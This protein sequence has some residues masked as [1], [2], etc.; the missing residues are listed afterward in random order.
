MSI[1]RHQSTCVMTPVWLMASYIH[2]YCY[3]HEMKG[4]ALMS[5]IFVHVQENKSESENDTLRMFKWAVIFHFTYD[6]H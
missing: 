2:K 4:L 1:Y 6:P 5:S 3:F